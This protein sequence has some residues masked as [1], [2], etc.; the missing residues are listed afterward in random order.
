MYCSHCTIAIM[1]HGVAEQ[2]VDEEI[3]SVET[4]SGSAK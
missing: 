1:L 2:M 3:T 4:I